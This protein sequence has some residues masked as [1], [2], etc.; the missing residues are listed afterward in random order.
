ML[1]I[2]A[3]ALGCGIGWYRAGKRG[4][5]T[6]DRIQYALAHGIPA[7]LATLAAISIYARVYGVT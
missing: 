2:F 6:P 3:F 1:V 5:S 4:G 7:A